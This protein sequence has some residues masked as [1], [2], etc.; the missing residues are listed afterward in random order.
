MDADYKVLLILDPDSLNNEFRSAIV[1]SSEMFL[2]EF[3]GLDEMKILLKEKKNI[4]F[5]TW[6][7]A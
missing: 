2:D 3:F 7:K 1:K 5:S 6:G 4:S